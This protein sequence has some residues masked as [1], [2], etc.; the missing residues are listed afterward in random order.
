VVALPRANWWPSR[1][2]SLRAGESLRLNG[3]DKTHVE[4][5]AE[6]E[7][8]LPPILV[9][10][11]SLRVID[12]MHRLLAASLKKSSGWPCRP[13]WRTGCRC[14]MVIAGPRQSELLPRIRICQ[15]GPSERRPACR[16]RP[17]PRCGVQPMRCRS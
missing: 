12:G 15:T 14:P 5:L 6:A 3:E 10:R 1:V 13:T 16:P 9:E 17:W 4:R 7:G 11:R 8:P 2:L